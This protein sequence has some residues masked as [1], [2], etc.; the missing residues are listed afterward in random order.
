MIKGK[1]VQQSLGFFLNS[2][3]LGSSFRRPE[4]SVT[5]QKER[6]KVTKKTLISIKVSRF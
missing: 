6:R 3:T 5:I 4:F 2:E 1:F